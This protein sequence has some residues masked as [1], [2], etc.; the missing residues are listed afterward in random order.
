MT[1]VSVI[2][3]FP[4]GC[5]LE[6]ITILQD[7]GLFVTCANRQQLYYIPPCTNGPVAP[8]LVHTFAADQW[9]M[10]IIAAPSNLN[11]FYLLTTDILRQGSQKSY[12]H[13]VDTANAGTGGKPYPILTFPSDARGLNGFCALSESVLLAADSFASCIWRIDLDLSSFPPK[14]ANAQIWHRHTTMAATLVLPDFQPGINGLKYSG[15]T[16]CVYYSSTQ[17][18]LFCRVHV[19]PKTFESDGEAEVIATGMQADD[20]IIDDNFSSGPVAYV[21]THRENSILRVP[22]DR[23]NKAQTTDEITSVVQG[24]DQDELVLGPTAGVWGI[25]TEGKS[26]YFTTDGGLKNPLSDGL[27]R[28]AKVVRVEL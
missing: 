10:G 26:A 1:K 16:N 12:L 13:V 23:E 8:F 19:N 4:Q 3:I 28:C 25:S 27:V 20:F 17:Q 11:V 21:T 24:S 2:S 14:T 6:N 22:L 5:F 18:K 7:G 15:K 9:A